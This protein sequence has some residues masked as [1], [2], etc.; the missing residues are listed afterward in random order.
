MKQME[1][2][3]Q[4]E[5]VQRQAEPPQNQAETAQRQT[6]WQQQPAALPRAKTAGSSPAAAGAAEERAAQAAE[7]EQEAEE[8]YSKWTDPRLRSSLQLSYAL[9]TMAGLYLLYVEYGMFQTRGINTGLKQLI[10]YGFMAIFAVV[11]VL[12][13][14]TGIRGL[15][16]LHDEG[17]KWGL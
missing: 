5:A 13:L 4:T 9:R 8:A 17:K 16:R 14:Y 11:A 6:E 15:K 2:P 7:P 12:F 10:S 1:E 3:K